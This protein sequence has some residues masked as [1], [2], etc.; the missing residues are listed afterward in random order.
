MQNFAFS[1]WAPINEELNKTKGTVHI[2]T[3]QVLRGHTW[4]V[5]TILGR[6]DREH[7]CLCKIFHWTVLK[8]S[9]LESSTLPEGPSIFSPCPSPTAPHLFTAKP[10]ANK[11]EESRVGWGRE[12]RHGGTYIINPEGEEKAFLCLFIFT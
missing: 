5:A 11:S 7:F 4:L 12:G 3:F 2:H 8:R 10:V 6:S 1:Y 9:S